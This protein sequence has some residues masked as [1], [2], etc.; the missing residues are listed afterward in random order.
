MKENQL[1]RTDGDWPYSAFTK[2]INHKDSEGYIQGYLCAAQILVNSIIAEKASP[3]ILVFPIFFVFRH[4]FELRLKEIITTASHVVMTNRKPASIH[5]LSKLW[6]V[7]MP[8][9]IHIDRN[10]AQQA[11]LRIIGNFFEEFQNSDPHATAFRYSTDKSNNASLEDVEEINILSAAKKCMEVGNYLE[12][13]SCF[14]ENAI[15]FQRDSID[16]SVGFGE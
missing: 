11:D 12:G 13:I 10:R 4:Y 7:A 8:M 6:S 9:L 3:D 1:F 16:G 15:E 14:L 2:G 5:D